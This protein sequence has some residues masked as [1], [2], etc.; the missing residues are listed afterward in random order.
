MPI[1]KS[2]KT[3]PVDKEAIAKAHNEIKEAASEAVDVWDTKCNVVAQDLLS[4]AREK[5]EDGEIEKGDYDFIWRIC[6]SISVVGTKVECIN[7]AVI[8]PPPHIEHGNLAEHFAALTSSFKTISVRLEVLGKILDGGTEL[9]DEAKELVKELK[10]VD[11]RLRK[12]KR[13]LKHW[14]IPKKEKTT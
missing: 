10:H 3:E 12:M 6:A 5:L 13:Q 9:K 1:F 8:Q 14:K 11:A 2:K 7:I 4:K